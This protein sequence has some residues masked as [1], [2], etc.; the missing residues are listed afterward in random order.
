VW[1][2]ITNIIINLHER[3]INIRSNSIISIH[4]IV[5]NDFA[6]CSFVFP[7]LLLLLSLTF[8]T[9]VVV[10]AVAASLFLLTF[11]FVSPILDVTSSLFER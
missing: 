4:C 8:I 6:C 9:L 5:I 2:R 3:I 11:F 10:A 1:R 7:C